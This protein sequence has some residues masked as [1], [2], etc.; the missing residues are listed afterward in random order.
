[1]EFFVRVN[2]NVLPGIR[3]GKKE[4]GSYVQIM[5][6]FNI[7]RVDGLMSGH[8]GLIEYALTFALSQVLNCEL[9]CEGNVT[10]ST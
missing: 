2:T 9:F 10:R 3:A 5:S 4:T 7:G 8:L 1:M 6:F